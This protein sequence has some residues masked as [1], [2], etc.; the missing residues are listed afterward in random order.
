[1]TSDQVED[2]ESYL[3]KSVRETHNFAIEAAAK[4]AELYEDRTIAAK[5]RT[6]LVEVTQNEP[7]RPSHL[8][9]IDAP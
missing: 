7:N 8:K 2:M 3:I 5:I 1:M 9:G 4:I 6:L